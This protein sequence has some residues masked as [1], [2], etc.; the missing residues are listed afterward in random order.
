MMMTRILVA[1]LLAG[2]GG[3]AMAQDAGDIASG[4]WQLLALNG[5][6]FGSE[7]TLALDA[8]GQVSGK[9]ACN[10][11][12]G[13]NQAALPAL[14]FGAMGATRMFC[15]RM[16]DETRYLAALPAVTAAELRD[17]HLILTGGGVTLEFVR[18]RGDKALICLTCG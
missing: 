1:A 6:A 18:D 5:A 7:T 8:A 17:G 2:L 16:E 9:A 12:F 4:E 3:A 14:Q 15:D 11:Y 10:R 13:A